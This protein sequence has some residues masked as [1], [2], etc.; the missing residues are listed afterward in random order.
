MKSAR[1]GRNFITKKLDEFISIMADVKPTSFI[2]SGIISAG[3]ATH[4]EMMAHD[5]KKM[6]VE[7]A[8]IGNQLYA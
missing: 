1:N 8:T 4:K 2:L 7:N 5:E 6:E 3:T